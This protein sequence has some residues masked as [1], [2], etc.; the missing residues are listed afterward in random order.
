MTP[1]LGENIPVELIC[2][3]ERVIQS[4]AR[5][6]AGNIIAGPMLRSKWQWRLH[7]SLETGAYGMSRPN[8]RWR[9]CLWMCS[10]ICLVAWTLVSFAIW[11]L[12]WFHSSSYC[13]SSLNKQSYETN[14]KIRS[15]LHLWKLILNFVMT[16]ASALFFE[17]SR[18]SWMSVL[19][20]KI[21]LIKYI[22]DHQNQAWDIS[23]QNC[24]LQ[25]ARHRIWS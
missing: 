5:A 4:S 11:S 25:C 12:F 24:W 7:C 10:A 21:H 20:T 3:R 17:R 23:M 14:Q 13:P 1:N 16:Q 22:N 19:T 8:W 6:T 9:I 15:S 18:N 2:C